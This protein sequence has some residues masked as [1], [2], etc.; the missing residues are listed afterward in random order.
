[1]TTAFLVCSIV[2]LGLLCSAE[3]KFEAFTASAVPHEPILTVIETPLEKG[4]F[5]MFCIVCVTFHFHP[6]YLNTMPW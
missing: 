2:F 1:M 6:L 5:C 4:T 3:G